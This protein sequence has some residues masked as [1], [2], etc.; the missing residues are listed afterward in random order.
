MIGGA[1]LVTQC[2]R[3][4][5]TRITTG[6]SRL[7]TSASVAPSNASMQ[8]RDLRQAL[9]IF[10]REPA[11]A[12]AA[13]VTLALGIG[14]NTAL[15]AIVE[16]VLLRPLPFERADDLVVLRHRDVQ[17]G[18]TKPDIAAGRFPRSARAAAV[19]RVARRVRR[20]PIHVFRRRRGGARPGRQRDARRAAGAATPTSARTPAAGRRRAGRRRAG[21]DGEPRVLAHAAR[22]RSAGN[23]ALD[24]AGSHTDDG[25]GRAACGFPLPRHAD[26]RPDRAAA[27]AGAVPAQR[28]SGWIY[29]IGRL[30][31]GQTL[32]Q[33]AA[34]MATLSQQF[35]TEFPEQNK[36]T[37]Y[38]ALSLRESL[39]GDT[40]RP[41]LLLLGAVG[42]VLLMACAN[43]GNLM[44]ARALGRQQE[45]AVRL[46][47]GASPGVW[48]C[49]CS[50]KRSAS[51]SPAARWPSSSRGT[52]RPILAALVPNALVGAGPR[53]GRRQPARAAVRAR[54]VRRRD[55][56]LRRR[57]VPRPDASRY[58]GRCASGRAR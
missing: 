14:A 3:R 18:L 27:A 8:M 17:T 24:S 49:T 41:L 2:R 9:R 31:A 4:S 48:Q 50:R 16:A 45:L 53:D 6:P 56:D 25:G 52:P 26:D 21:R 57:R 23:R 42:F 46:A 29:G 5:R 32:E 44:L 15:F 36:G 51:P 19:A 40:R 1:F 55:A 39:V 12:A 54:H 13:V 33:A 58:A 47:L 28:K 22:I 30:R 37:R 11:F 7:T 35:E 34:E 38:E 10:R 20:I 43:V